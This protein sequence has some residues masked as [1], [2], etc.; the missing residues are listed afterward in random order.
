MA[1][2]VP[3]DR[4]TCCKEPIITGQ[5]ALQKN[6]TIL[7]RHYPP[8]GTCPDSGL[9][10]FSY[11]KVELQQA[12]LTGVEYSTSVC[13]MLLGMTAMPSACTCTEIAHPLSPREV[14]IMRL[15]GNWLGVQHF[16]GPV[17]VRTCTT[18]TITITDCTTIVY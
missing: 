10:N 5:W 9:I 16:L 2:K 6:N 14:D 1:R 12:I 11:R 17:Y 4:A 8:K 7:Q 13:H 15:L 3:L 18:I